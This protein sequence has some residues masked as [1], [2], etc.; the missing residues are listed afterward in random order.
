MSLPWLRDCEDVLA[1]AVRD[2]S[3]RRIGLLYSGG[4]ESS[5]LLKLLEPHRDHVSVFTVR[6]G[7]EFPHMVSFI[8]RMISGWDHHV[9][10]RD[11]RASLVELGLPASV[12][13]IEHTPAFAAH[14]NAKERLPRIVPWTLCCSQNR[15]PFDWALFH[16]LQINVVVNGQ[17]AGDFAVSKP[18]SPTAPSQR[19]PDAPPFSIITPLWHVSREDVREAVAA[20]CVELPDH[21][22]AHPDSLDCSICPASLTSARRTWMAGRYPQHLAVAETLHGAVKQATLAALDADNTTKARDQ[23]Q[24]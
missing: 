4:L 21:Y 9:I 17:R 15:S 11:L 5:L 20:L 6:T 18:P 3:P 8:D 7:E 24:E 10:K 22:A 16:S 12:L 23:Q 1:S 14:M 19:E 13:P 2:A